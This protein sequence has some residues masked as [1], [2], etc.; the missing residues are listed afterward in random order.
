MLPVV[1]VAL[2]AAT[3]FTFKDSLAVAFDAFT[4]HIEQL[5]PWAWPAYTLAYFVLECAL[6]PAIPLTMSAGVVLGVGPGV[7]ASNR[8]DGDASACAEMAKRPLET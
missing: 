5:G 8:F 4:V 2:F 3:A 7:P 1:G 6:V